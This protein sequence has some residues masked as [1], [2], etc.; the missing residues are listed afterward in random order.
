MAFY[1]ISAR[2]YGQKAALRAL[3][4]DKPFTFLT[5]PAG[6]GKTLVAQA[7]GLHRLLDD[8]K[9][10]KLVYTRLQEQ[11]G[12][13]LGAIPGDFNEKTYP[14]IRP[15]LDNLDVMTG[16]KAE[17]L[18]YLTQGDEKKR[19]VSFDPI[20]TLR[21]GTLHNAYGIFDEIQ[22]VDVSTLAGIATR[23]GDGSKFIFCGNFAQIDN[24][25]LRRPD[26]NG[27]YR[28]LTGLYELNA[29]AFFD[30]VNL[31]VVERHPAAEI[32]EKI[33]R[34]NEIAPEFEALEAR[35]IIQ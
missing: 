16:A 15:F 31:T 10:R 3:A 14:F 12:K 7:V 35:G 28:L 13:D 2:N 18:A 27:L 19:K 34:D 23:I 8:Q 4:N 25:R 24:E 17:T 26:K 9:Y 6:T 22:N 11:L 1:G 30:H 29:H 20:Q 33:L 32:V 21:G 5:G